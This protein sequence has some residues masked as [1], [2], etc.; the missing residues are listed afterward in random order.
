[1]AGG[2]MGADAEAQESLNEIKD[3]V[4]SAQLEP[5]LQ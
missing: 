3:V 2:R 4:C 1:M 5:L